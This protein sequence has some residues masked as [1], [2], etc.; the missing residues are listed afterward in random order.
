[1]LRVLMLLQHVKAFEQKPQGR[2]DVFG[3]ALH[4][5]DTIL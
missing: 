1:M 4:Q 3:F 5:T 2:L